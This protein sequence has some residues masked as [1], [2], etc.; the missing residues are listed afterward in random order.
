[1][2]NNLTNPYVDNTGAPLSP[3][4]N[5]RT[6]LKFSIQNERKILKAFL[7]GCLHQLFCELFHNKI[8][9]DKTGSSMECYAMDNKIIQILIEGIVETEEYTL[10][11]IAHVT[12]IPFDVIFDAARGN[13]NN[14]FSCTLWTRIVDIYMQVKPEIIQ[15]LFNK[16]I[17]IKDKHHLALSILLNE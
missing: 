12:R 2:M 14:Q 11:G 7:L 8:Q 17:E 15:L 3:S 10:E 6:A 9:Q 13:S 1:M 5:G 16:I 4:R